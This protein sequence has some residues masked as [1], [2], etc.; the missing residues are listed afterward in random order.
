MSNNDAV[1]TLKGVGP[2]MAKKLE[3]M[4]LERIVDV[5]EHVPFRYLD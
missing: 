2:E 4:G 5:L 3:T 1:T